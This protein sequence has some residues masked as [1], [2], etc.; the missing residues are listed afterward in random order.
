MKRADT[1][2]LV[3]KPFAH[4]QSSSSCK[5]QIPACRY[6]VFSEEH[7]FFKVA[8]QV[9]SHQVIFIALFSCLKKMHCLDNFQGVF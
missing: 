9:K 3:L 2:R 7:C 8:Y 6:G 1:F 4:S 5:E